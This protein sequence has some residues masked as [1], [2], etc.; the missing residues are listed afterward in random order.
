MEAKKKADELI[1]MFSFDCTAEGYRN[2]IKMSLRC[3]DEIIDVL[4][5]N[6]GNSINKTILWW[7]EVKEEI[8][9]LQ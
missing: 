1:E 3:I 9:E 7:E 4:K 8:K 6:E 2:G 5:H